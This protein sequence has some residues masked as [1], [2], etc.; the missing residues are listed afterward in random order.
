MRSFVVV[1]IVLIA[2]GN[3]GKSPPGTGS[4]TVVTDAATAAG[5][6]STTTAGGSAAVAGD[7]AKFERELVSLEQLKTRTCACAD[8][9][10]VEKIGLEYQTWKAS[11][12]IALAGKKPNKVQE[13]RGNRLE[14]E[15]KACYRWV[16]AGLGSGAG[17]SEAN[18]QVEIALVE[19]ERY[20]DKLCACSDVGC[21]DNITE[22]KKAWERALRTRLGATRPEDKQKQ[23]GRLFEDGMAE[24]RKRIA[25]G[26]ATD[27][28]AAVR[29]DLAVAELRGLKS[30]MCA[31]ADAACTEKVQAEYM[32]WKEALAR[33]MKGKQPTSDQRQRGD[34]VHTEFKNCREKHVK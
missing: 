29:F 1:A 20:R 7:D 23:R 8:L 3:N 6:G 9:P 11:A 2:C 24:C 22:E 28:A 19:L 31:C 10:C 4:A 16:E 21:A 33:D 12:K 26:G 32:A 14:D 25:G 27:P 13:E 18:A 15:M 17:G 34:Q 5:S 30:K